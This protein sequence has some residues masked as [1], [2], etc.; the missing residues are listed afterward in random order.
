M[1]RFALWAPVIAYMAAIFLVSANPSP[2]MP[3]RVSDKAL[4]LVAYFGLAALAFRAVSGGLTAPIS[5]R[6]TMTA[7]VITIGYAITDELH[8]SFVPGRS[9]DVYD[10][11]ADAA[12]AFLAPIA[13]KAW[14]ILRT[15]KSQIPNPRPQS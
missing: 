5:W 4:H 3:A 11:I 1:S 2:P 6:S 13:L 12:G 15:P 9:A 14:D 8:Q 10:V 7:L